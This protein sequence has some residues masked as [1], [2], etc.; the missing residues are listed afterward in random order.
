VARTGRLDRQLRPGWHHRRRD[1]VRGETGKPVARPLAGP[2]GTLG[3][4]SNKIRSQNRTQIR[5]VE[6]EEQEIGF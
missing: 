5:A 1:D 4:S 2:D 6:A 3:G